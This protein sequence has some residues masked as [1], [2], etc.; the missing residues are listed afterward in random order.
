MSRKSR[1]QWNI[2][3]IR[4]GVSHKPESWFKQADSM[5]GDW[6]Y[7]VADS[8]SRMKGH[9]VLVGLKQVISISNCVSCR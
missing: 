3:D 6:T 7:A 5:L 8:S 1:N 9:S 2:A 4:V